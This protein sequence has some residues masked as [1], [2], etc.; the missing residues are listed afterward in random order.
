MALKF[1]STE[2]V[3]YFMD[4]NTLPSMEGLLLLWKH[5]LLPSMELR[6]KFLIEIIV[7]LLP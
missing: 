7:F 2:E 4:L 6:W 3:N 5:Y 1:T